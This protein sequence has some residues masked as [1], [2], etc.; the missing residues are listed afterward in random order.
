[1]SIDE[2][3]AGLEHSPHP[4]RLACL[5]ESRAKAWASALW[6]AIV[7]ALVLMSAPV[8]AAPGEVDQAEAGSEADAH[9]GRDTAVSPRARAEGG[10]EVEVAAVKLALEVWRGG[11]RPP[12][13]RRIPRRR[14][15]VDGRVTYELREP[16]RA[17]DRLVLLDFAEFMSGAPKDV[18]EIA[19]STYIAGPAERARTRVHRAVDGDGQTLSYRREGSRRDLVVELPAGA[20][21]ITLEY[22]VEVPHR[23]WPLGCVWRHCSLSG[24]LA[25]LPSEAAQGGV[26]LPAE[27]R[28]I[29]PARWEIESLRFG[30]V[31]DWVPGTTP[32]KE[33]RDGLGGQ[34]LFAA[35]EATDPRAAIAYPSVFWGPNWKHDELWHRGVRIRV[36]H[37]ERRPGDRYPDEALLNPIRD[38][39][40]HVLAI[41][42]ENIDLAGALG[43]EPPPGSELV[44]VQGPVRTDVAQFHPTVVTVSDQYLELLATK[45]LAK[46][47]DLMVAR[48][49]GDLLAYGHFAGRQGASTE[50]WLPSALGVA[51]AQL[52]Q[53]QRDLRDEYAADLLASFTFVPAIDRFLYTGQ[54][55]FSSAYFRGSEDEMPVR[56][57]PLYFANELPTG[58]RIHEK[59]LDL[60]GEGAI[61]R[62]YADLVAA[63]EDDYERVAERAWGRELGWFFDQWLGPYPEVDYAIGDVRHIELPTG[64]WRTEIDIIRDADRPLV[65][66][67]QVY[68]VE[69]GGQD[70]YLVWNGEAE[71]GEGLLEQPRWHRHTFVIETQQRVEVVRLDPRRRL[72]Q[73]SRSPV[74]RNNRGDNNDPLF[75]DRTPAKSRFLYT[76]V[77]LS[78]AASEFFAQGTPPQTRINAVT[79][80]LAFEASLQRDLRKTANFLIFTDRETNVGGSASLNY[81]FGKKRNRQRR[82][83][84]LRTSASVSWLNRS[85]LD[86]EGGVRLT[87][88]VRLTKDTRRFTLWPERGHVLTAGI[89]SSQTIRTGGASDHR[90]SLDLDAG[91]TQLWPLAHH[92]VLATRLDT[93]IVIPL[94]SDPEFRTLNRAGGIG[95]LTGFT[96][97]ELFGQ[98][99]ALAAVEYRHVIVDDLRLPLL[100][101]LWLRTIG[102]ALFGGTA[103]LSSCEGL[104]G[105]FG[106]GSWYGYV[107]YGLSARMQILGVTPQFFRVDASVPIGRRTGQVCLGETFPDYLATSQGR[108]AEDAEKLLPPFSINVTFNQP[109]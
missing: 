42:Q 7:A 23:Y 4:G 109:F 70:H 33:Q 9:A 104:D 107:G 41:A 106:R 29:A 50:V 31:P 26:W 77:G 30:A 40:G 96:G 36:L 54:A 101:L 24:A 8:S 13:R 83:L 72:R 52:W 25:P 46:F 5:D 95:G 92:H 65:E 78:L 62:F 57:H 34:E 58:R 20:H 84:R 91:W 103:T 61:A 93:S 22:S 66:P 59:F 82:Q 102:G 85:G 27:G 21:A 11:D 12:E 89:S 3:S 108:P 51:L 10:R 37:L 19:L 18:D 2:R 35:G 74:G 56:Y 105:W 80:F 38:V 94:F 67:V 28:V 6:R 97:N 48:S 99:V 55:A 60:A 15:E 98:G 17:G 81:Y 53:R 49:V 76:G 43:I 14:A 73:S 44:V 79:A 100:N 87:E 90:Y 16:A 1:M 86:T 68:L 39:A 71:P 32:T 64:R 75:N 69:R 47:H 45:R 63:P 88:T